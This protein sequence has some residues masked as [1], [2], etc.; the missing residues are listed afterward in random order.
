MCMKV[1]LARKADERPATLGD[2]ILLTV[3]KLVI[4]V[5]KMPLTRPADGSDA[6]EAV[7]ISEYHGD[8]DL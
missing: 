6:G 7:V 8:N 2:E 1:G 5:I 4:S 3:L